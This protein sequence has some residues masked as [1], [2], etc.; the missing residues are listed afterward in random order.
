M[1]RWSNKQAKLRLETANPE[2]RFIGPF[3]DHESRVKCSCRKCGHQWAPYWYVITR[4][5]GC[6]KCATNQK[7]TTALVRRRLKQINPKIKI[8][9]T[10]SGQY[11]PLLVQCRRCGHE[12]SPMWSN[13]SAGCGCPRCNH[14][15]SV[16]ENKIRHILERITKHKFARSYPNFLRNKTS[17]RNLELDGYSKTLK[18]AFEYQGEQHYGLVHF[19]GS[20]GDSKKKLARRKSLDRLKRRLCRRYGVRLLVISYRIVNLE[21]YIVKRLNTLYP[22]FLLKGNTR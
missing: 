22:E 5:S 7:L 13:L 1:S 8:I 12:W 19:N 20:S 21:Q 17:G 3:K 18:L 14:P 16:K 6:P 4:G 9:G 15:G 10:Y 2:V 11:H